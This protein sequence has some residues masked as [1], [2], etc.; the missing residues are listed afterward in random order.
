MHFIFYAG[1]MTMA[2]LGKP[3]S[4]ELAKE[5]LELQIV[6]ILTSYSLFLEVV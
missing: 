5:V 3:L 6:L 2:G 1:L 4:A